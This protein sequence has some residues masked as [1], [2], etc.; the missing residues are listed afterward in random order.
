MKWINELKDPSTGK[1]LPHLLPVDQ[2]LHWANPP[3]GTRGRDMTADCAASPGPYTGPVPI[4][5]HLHGA[6][7]DPES[8]GFPEAWYLPDASNIPAGVRH[9]RGSDFGQLARSAARS[10]A[11]DL[12][13]P[14]RP[15]GDDALVPRPHARHDP[16]QRVRRAG[17]LLPAARRARRSRRAACFPVPPPR[18][19]RPARHTFYEI[20]IAIQ[21]RSFNDDGSLFYPDSRDFFD[22][23][24]AGPFIPRQR[25]LADLEPG[26]LRQHHGRQRAHLAVAR[27]RAAPLPAS[28]S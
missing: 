16:R 28:A 8:D 23:V 7:V 9:A 2:T 1:F 17:R 6:H 15:A 10:G 20:P 19:G 4:V 21:D 27:G 5:T 24:H 12:P 13:V 3:G 26:V 25:R 18:V 22:G 11:G 14:E